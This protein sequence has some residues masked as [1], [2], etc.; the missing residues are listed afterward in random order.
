MPLPKVTD[1]QQ[2]DTNGEAPKRLVKLVKLHRDKPDE[3][4]RLLAGDKPSEPQE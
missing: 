1:P 4:R 2:L 3:A